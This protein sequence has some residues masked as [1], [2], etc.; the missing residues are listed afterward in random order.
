M[1]GSLTKKEL[2][3]VFDLLSNTSKQ[4]PSKFDLH[5]HSLSL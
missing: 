1:Y 5:R 4:N 2:V 3:F